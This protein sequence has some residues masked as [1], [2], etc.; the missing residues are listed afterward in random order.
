[1]T[2][3]IYCDKVLEPVVS[4]WCEDKTSKWTLCEDRDSGHGLSNNNNI[5]RQW[6]DSYGIKQHEGNHRYYFS[7]PRTP[8]FNIIEN[9]WQSPKQYLL[10][11]PHWDDEVV[12]ETAE[13][14]WNETS[15][16]WINS[17]VNDIPRRLRDCCEV[18]DGQRP[19]G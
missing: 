2:Q 14:K 16:D 3:K 9:V 1:M 10:L 8:E 15:Q 5:V 7:C 17:L 13:A 4:K 11:R 12:W 19:G 18:L 6:K